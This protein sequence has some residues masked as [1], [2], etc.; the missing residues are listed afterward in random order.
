MVSHLKIVAQ[1]LL[2]VAAALTLTSPSAAQDQAS[3]TG[4]VVVDHHVHVHS[5]GM[6]K[7]LPVFCAATSPSGKC[8]DTFSE[9]RSIAELVKAMD[10][11]GIK[12]GVLLSSG[13]LAES[14]FIKPPATNA[15]AV[16][17]EAN[18]FVAAASRA[19]PDRLSAF[20][21]INPLTTTALSE[22]ERFRADP[23]VI[24]IKLHL[25]N[26]GVDLRSPAD[27]ARLAAVIRAAAGHRMVILIHMRNLQKDYGRRDA[28]IFIRDVLPAAQGSYVQV[29]HAGGWGGITEHTISA[30]SAFADAFDRHPRRM[31]NVYFDLAAVI[32]KSN[33]PSRRTE[34]ATL[35]R[36]IGPRHFLPA[37]DYPYATDLKD[38]YAHTY[39]LLALSPAEWRV[40]RGRVAPYAHGQ[41]RIAR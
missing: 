14:V 19:Y 21:G 29:A 31:R 25:A 6:L 32:D 27:V 2:I 17:R 33:E 5:P 26:S 12:R 10:D 20:I 36:R 4:K 18:D 3:S 15:A 40:L 24:G 7:F 1:R 41:R 35:V 8:D 22:I 37:S 30:L 11:A 39:S 9:E 34:L 38:Y 28:E 13:Y 16:L 23:H